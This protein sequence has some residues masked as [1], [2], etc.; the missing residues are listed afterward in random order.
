MMKVS[1]LRGKYSPL[2]EATDEQKAAIASIQDRAVKR[3]IRRFEIRY[4]TW[5]GPGCAAERGDIV[6]MM[7]GGI[8]AMVCPDG[9]IY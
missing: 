9:T 7:D 8:G 4:S 6:V 3:G 1:G 2:N 5:I